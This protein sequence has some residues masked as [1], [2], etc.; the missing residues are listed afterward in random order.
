M[1]FKIKYHLIRNLYIGQL[2]NKSIVFKCAGMINT[3]QKVFANFHIV[4][5]QQCRV[6]VDQSNIP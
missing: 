2:I 1:N 5:P 6:L 3:I 4:L